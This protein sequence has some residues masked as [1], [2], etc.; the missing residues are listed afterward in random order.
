MTTLTHP[1]TAKD[2]LQQE[3]D[4]QKLMRIWAHKLPKI[5]LHRHLEGSLR[6]QTLAEIAMEHGIDLPSYDVEQLRPYVQ[7]TDDYPDFHRFLEK[8]K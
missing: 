1:M 6:L 4:S 5:D 8:F 3:P 7:V 2:M